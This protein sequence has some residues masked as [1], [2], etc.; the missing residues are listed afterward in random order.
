MIR[1][2]KQT[3]IIP[4]NYRSLESICK[5]IPFIQNF[6]KRTEYLMAQENRK[7]YIDLTFLYLL[8]YTH[9]Q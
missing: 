1:N 7:K 4:G 3:G 8:E 2:P 6:P 5:F 9:P